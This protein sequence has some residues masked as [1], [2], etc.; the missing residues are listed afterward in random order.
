[1]NNQEK[2]S[3]LESLTVSLDMMGQDMNEASIQMMARELYSFPFEVV[4]KALRLAVRECKY[5]LNLAEII[6]RIDD[7]RPSPTQAWQSMSQFKESDAYYVPDEMHRAWCGVS[8]DMEHA[9]NSIK[10]ACRQ[11]FLETYEKM[12]QES[13]DQGK[14][15]SYFL[16]QPQG[17][18]R[19]QKVL[20]VITKAIAQGQ[21][22]TDKAVAYLPHMKSEIEQGIMITHKHDAELAGLIG[23]IAE[24]KRME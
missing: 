21:I 23:V 16:S 15:I 17:I 24:N 1:M 2:G 3:V 13:C 11:S 9:D 19:E 4:Q 20:E 7:G 5:K 6:S 18:G 22:T 10:I 12:C 14:P 8:T